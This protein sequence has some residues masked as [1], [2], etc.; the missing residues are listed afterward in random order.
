M[1]GRQPCGLLHRSAGTGRNQGNAAFLPR[2]FAPTAASLDSGS[3]SDRCICEFTAWSMIRKSMPS[4][5]DPM[6]GYRFPLG[7]NTKRL[8][9]DGAMVE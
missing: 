1:V 2:A 8:P 7:T 4:G 5:H 9:G 6:G 3:Q